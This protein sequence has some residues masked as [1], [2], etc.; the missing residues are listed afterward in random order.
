[1][2]AATQGHRGRNPQGRTLGCPGKK[3][4][5]AGAVARSG[6]LPVKTVADTLEVV[7]SNLVE[8]AKRGGAGL[9]PYRRPAPRAPHT[10]AERYDRAHARP[11]QR[12]D[13]RLDARWF[14]ADPERRHRVRPA[15]QEEVRL[16]GRVGGP[17]LLDQGL[18]NRLADNDSRQLNLQA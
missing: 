9:D 5:V 3:V 4:A 8:Q 18:L 13:C 12:R 2:P 16:L 11:V 15:D 17:T 1:M 14:K 6:R 7:R 10:T